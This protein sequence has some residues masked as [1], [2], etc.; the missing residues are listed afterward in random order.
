M[1]FNILYL[2]I[3]LSILFSMTACK[4]PEEQLKAADD[5]ARNII[6][7]KSDFVTRFDKEDVDIVLRNLEEI[8]EMDKQAIID[9]REDAGVLHLSVDDALR[10]AIANNHSYKRNQEDLYLACLSLSDERHRF[11]FLFDDVTEATMRRDVNREQVGAASNRLSVS[12]L[13]SAG[14][15]V[16]A[17]ILNGIS[18]FYTGD[19]RRTINSLLSFNLVQPLMRGYGSEIVKEQ[20]TQTE[21]NVIYEMRSFSRFQVNFSLELIERYYNLLGTQDQ[22][23]NEYN[24]YERLVVSRIRAENLAVDRRP[25]FEVDQT[26]QDELQARNRYILAV[27][28]YRSELEDFKL[29]VGITPNY[30]ITLDEGS[31]EK[32]RNQKYGILEL[33][34]ETAY[35]TAL[36]NRMDFLNELDQF[37]DSRRKINVAVNDLG[38]DF[39]FLADFSLGNA[40]D[41]NIAK[42]N[43]KDWQGGVG[44]RIDWPLDRLNERNQLR[45]QVISF[46]RQ[47]RS[48]ESA[49][50]NIRTDLK[51]R[52]R[53]LE[54]S[55]KTIDIQKIAIELAERRVESANILLEAGRA[56]TRDLLEAQSAFVTAKNNYTTS[57]ISYYL[58]RLDLMQ[59]MGVLDL[60]QGE[61]KEGMELAFVKA[62]EIEELITPN[63]VFLD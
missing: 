18:E 33:D 2:S 26:R 56:T 59:D 39:D 29:F 46:E 17:G 23:K 37:D 47:L 16:T 30:R 36:L 44:V 49:V 19:S 48:L 21:R 5:G 54:A 7:E 9:E 53:S 34:E 61:L 42:F 1:K 27:D 6:S 38:A 43:F 35:K 60:E 14:G 12:K 32:L 40:N 13:L 52:I 57:L 15:T 25:E 55:R 8:A 63:Q 10:L 4:S 28:R 22:V 41:D 51:D 11:D 45:S 3:S 62:P 50:D 31:L 20:L 58:S 24:N